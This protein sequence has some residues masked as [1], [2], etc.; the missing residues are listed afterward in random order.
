MAIIPFLRRFIVVRAHNQDAVHAAGFSELCHFYGT[1]RAVAACPGDDRYAA[2]HILH[3][4]RPEE[5]FLLYGHGRRFPRRAGH[6]E[7]V[8]PMGQPPVHQF[9]DRLH[10][11]TAFVK[12]RYHSGQQSSEIRLFHVFLSFYARSCRIVDGITDSARM[13]HAETRRRPSGLL[14]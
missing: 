7:A 12:G 3:H 4:C 2:V 6:H 5:L 1:G 10:I 11:D 9:F 8:R 14:P 13:P